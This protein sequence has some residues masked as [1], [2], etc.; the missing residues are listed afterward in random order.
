MPCWTLRQMPAAL[1]QHESIAHEDSGYVDGVKCYCPTDNAHS[2]LALQRAIYAMP[3]SQSPFRMISLQAVFD[4][5]R[6]CQQQLGISQEQ[7][8]GNPEDNFLQYNTQQPQPSAN[9]I[10]IGQELKCWHQDQTGCSSPGD[11]PGPGQADEDDFIAQRCT[12]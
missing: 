2:Q 1:L 4:L 6:N 8:S 3:P 10:Q 12:Y 5:S 9:D 11:Y 7:L